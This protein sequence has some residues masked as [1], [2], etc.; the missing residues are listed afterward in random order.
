[1]NSQQRIFRCAD[2]EKLN[3]IVM[4]MMKHTRSTVSDLYY[5]QGKLYE[6][7]SVLAADVVIEELMEEN[8]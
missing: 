6:L 4:D 5:L 7:F 2:G 3:E 1:M 8:R